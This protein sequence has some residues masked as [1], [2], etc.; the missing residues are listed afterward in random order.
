M[1]LV[2]VHVLHMV[3]R[4]KVCTVGGRRGWGECRREGVGGRVGK[5]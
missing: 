5:V 4:E 3:N 2:C 1:K